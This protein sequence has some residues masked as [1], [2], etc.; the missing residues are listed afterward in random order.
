MAQINTCIR[1]GGVSNTTLY[2]TK[3]LAFAVVHIPLTAEKVCRC[4]GHYFYGSLIQCVPS[5]NL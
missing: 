3:E 1:M 4:D 2:S 5:L